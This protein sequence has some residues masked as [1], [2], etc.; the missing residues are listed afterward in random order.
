MCVG[1]LVPISRA[2]GIATKKKERNDAPIVTGK[3]TDVRDP[4][5]TSKV[6]KRLKK[7]RSQDDPVKIVARGKGRSPFDLKIM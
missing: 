6:T 5:D 3:Q 4:I 2:V 7:Q 1:P